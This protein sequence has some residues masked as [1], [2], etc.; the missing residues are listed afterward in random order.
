MKK[1]ISIIIISLIFI[2]CSNN[3]SLI[4]NYKKPDLS[5]TDF[6]Y[7]KDNVFKLKDT[8]FF[9]LFINY[10]VSFKSI[11]DEF[12]CSTLWDN[13]NVDYNDKNAVKEQV[14]G[15]LRLIKELGFNSIRLVLDRLGKTENDKYYYR[16]NGKKYFVKEDAEAILNGFEQLIELIKQED[17]RVLVLIKA[18]VNNKDLEDFTIKMLNRFKNNSTIF[19]Y[20]FINEPLYFATEFTKTKADALKL[21]NHWKKMMI[22]HAPNQLFTLAFSEPLEVFVWDASIMPVDFVQMH[23]Y[24]PLRV[25]SEIYWYSKYIKKPFLIGETALP[26]DNDSLSYNE[27]R[28]FAKEVYQYAINAG[29][30]GF[31]WWQYQECQGNTYE[32]SFT[33]LLRKTGT[34]ATSDNKYKISGTL[35]PA[36]YVFKDLAKRK[37]QQLKRPVNYYN[38]I[39]YENICVKGTVVN[40]KTNKAVEGAVIRGWSEYWT[41]GMN[42]YSDENGNFTLYCNTPVRYFRI[43]A[44]GMQTVDIEQDL[45]YTNIT[46]KTYDINNLPN[47]DVEYQTIAYYPFIFNPEKRRTYNGNEPYILNFNPEKFNKMK[48]TAKL[49]KIYLK[50]FK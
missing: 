37:P 34:T 46:D 16:T 19:A 49:G 29:A 47:K 30:I 32:S 15:N 3:D 28:M 41:I 35:K 23:T 9:P 12:V 33:G 38:M 36:A 40:K 24:H 50:E 48:F 17:L 18:P 25:S 6:I 31:G 14:T 42:T 44:P 39:G 22:K 20:D 4:T 43:S 26:A 21:V 13:E 2:A 1:S 8:T 11:N 5:K 7:I 10:I 27:Q 45:D